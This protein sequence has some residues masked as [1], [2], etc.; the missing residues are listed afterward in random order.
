MSAAPY[1]TGEQ[2]ELRHG[3]QRAVVVEVGAGL[4]RYALGDWEVVDGYAAGEMVSAGRGQLLI[5]W[6]NRLRDGRWEHGQLALTEPPQ[7]HAIHGLVRWSAWRAVERSDEHVVLEHRLHPQPGWP[8]TLDLRAEWALGDGGL[9]VRVTAANPG[10]EPAPCAMGAHP[11]LSV[12]T[13]T[14]DEMVV[15]SPGTVRLLADERQIPTG[16]MEPVAGT[17]YDL[18]EP[19]ALGAL[20]VDDAFG[21]LARDPDGRARVRV[22]SPDGSRRA[23]LWM[24]EAYSHLMLFSADTLPGDARRRSLGVEPM[25]CAPNALQTGDGLRVLGPGESFTTA[26]GIAASAG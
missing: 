21:S 15:Q 26:W 3:D 16:E 10:D 22:A 24:D 20:R 4:R 14:V 18:R 11:Y 8:F 6:P 17:P 19:R 7:G 23:E 1:P 12:G 9:R 25:T 2:Y 5:P 13:P